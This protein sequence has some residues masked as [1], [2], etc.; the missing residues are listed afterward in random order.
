ME[1]DAGGLV[2]LEF[3]VDALAYLLLVQILTM[4]P[5]LL[6]RPNRT[7]TGSLTFFAPSGLLEAI[8]IILIKYNLFYIAFS[9]PIQITFLWP[10]VT[11]TQHKSSHS[12]LINY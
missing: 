11:I 5:H 9:I 7:D 2:Y 10:Y 1:G 6:Y 4:D 3:L 8:L 12:K